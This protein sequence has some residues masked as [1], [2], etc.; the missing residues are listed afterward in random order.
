MK[1]LF[2]ELAEVIL[3]RQA[4]AEERKSERKTTTKKRKGGKK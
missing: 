4:R 1:S 2:D 3:V